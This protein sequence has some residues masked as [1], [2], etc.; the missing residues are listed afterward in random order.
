MFLDQKW[1]Q[2][3]ILAS[4]FDLEATK[5]EILTNFENRSFLKGG[6]LKA[7]NCDFGDPLHRQR[8]G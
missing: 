5:S 2:N 8:E 7:K 4:N 6:T 1:S 3:S